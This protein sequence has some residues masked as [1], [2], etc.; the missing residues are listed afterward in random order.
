MRSFRFFRKVSVPLEGLGLQRMEVPHHFER[1]ARRRGGAM[2]RFATAMGLAATL[3]WA[4][5]GAACTVGPGMGTDAGN[6]GSDSSNPGTDGGG[7]GSDAANPG[8]DSAI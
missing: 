5:F 1:C 2:S 4:A 8:T 7:G 3:A 6:P